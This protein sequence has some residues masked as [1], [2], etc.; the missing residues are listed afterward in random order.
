MS[1]SRQELIKMPKALMRPIGRAIADHKM[2][3]EG[4]RI[5]L[6]LSGG[7]SI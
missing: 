3:N 2:I 5:V 6:G 4:D 1:D 7:N